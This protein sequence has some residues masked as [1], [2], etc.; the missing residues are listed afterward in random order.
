MSKIARISTTITARYTHSGGA[1]DAFWLD[2]RMPGPREVRAADITLDREDRGFFFSVFAA[3][4]ISKDPVYDLEAIRP[5]LDRMHMDIKYS[6]KNIDNLIVDFAECSTGVVGKKTIDLDGVRHPFFAGIIVKNAEVAAVTTGRGCAYLYRNDT[7]YPLTHDSL[8]FEPVDYTGRNVPNIEIYCAG[9]VGNVRYSNIAQ[10]QV[11]DCIIVCNKEIMAAIGQKEM[12]RILNEAYDQS[13]AAGMVITEAAS[14]LPGTTIQFMIGFVESITDGGKS[15]KTAA[16]AAVATRFAPR[17]RSAA[18]V[19]DKALVDA[20]EDDDYVLDTEEEEDEDYEEGYESS[21]TAKKIALL[22]V[23]LIVTAAC[24][25]AVWWTIFRNRGTNPGSSDISSGD[26][27]SAAVSGAESAG[28]SASAASEADPVSSLTASGTATPT[29]NPNPTKA[30]TKAP[31]SI[32]AT[33]TIAKGEWLSDI[34]N[35]YYGKS[36]AKY[37]TAIVNANKDKYPTFTTDKYQEGWIISIP[38]VD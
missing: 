34:A 28:T 19:P 8:G 9:N 29:V 11:D 25:F 35:K 18:P 16:A 26:P 7:L 17:S 32:I 6:A 24:I 22:A 27:I 12:L 1:T 38:K 20:A 2:S 37:L 14:K 36:T 30:P 31:S 23:I 13:D 4:S 33:H 10:L 21:T 3:P 15:A 5:A